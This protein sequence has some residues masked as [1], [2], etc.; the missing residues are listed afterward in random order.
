MTVY[1]LEY[2]SGGIIVHQLSCGSFD[3]ASLMG[4]GRITSLGAFDNS[5]L[6]LT[7]A[8]LDHSG[9]ARCLD[10]CKVDLLADAEATKRSPGKNFSLMM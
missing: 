8:R 7:A 3:L 4:E 1:C 2:G 10:C 5:V 9:A 6:A